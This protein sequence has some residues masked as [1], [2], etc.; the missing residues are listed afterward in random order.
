LIVNL[1]GPAR[2]RAGCSSQVVAN[3]TSSIL[4]ARAF[5]APSQPVNRTNTPLGKMTHPRR[6]TSV[7]KQVAA[8]RRTLHVM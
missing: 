2:V 8:I 4:K 1:P 3:Q 5:G 6:A 7:E